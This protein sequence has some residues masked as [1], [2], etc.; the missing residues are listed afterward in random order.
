MKA[1]VVLVASAL[2]LAFAACSSSSTEST[3]CDCSVEV[4]GD[5]RELTCGQSACVGGFNFT[6]GESGATKGNACTGSSSSSSSGSSS[7]SSGGKPTTSSS[8]S[9]TGGSADGCDD[10]KTYC[11]TKCKTPEAVNKSCNDAV[12]EGNGSKC[13]SWQAF[14]ASLCKP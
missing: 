4:N 9:S 12:A 13:A 6:C 7:S 8:T 1:V 14:N 3:T 11:S 10:L 5:K 2:T